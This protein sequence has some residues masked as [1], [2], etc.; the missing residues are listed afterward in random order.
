M[1]ISYPNKTGKRG[2]ENSEDTV[3]LQDETKLPAEQAEPVTSA[4]ASTSAPAEA[5]ET[6]AAETPK[7]TASTTTEVPATPVVL[8]L[9]NGTYIIVSKINGFKA[10]QTEGASTAAGKQMELRDCDGS[11]TQKFKLVG[12]PK[13]GFYTITNLLSGKVLAMKGNST[14]SGTSVVQNTAAAS[15]LGQKW[16]LVKKDGYYMF[17]SALDGTPLALTLKGGSTANGTDLVVTAAKGAASQLFSLLVSK[18]SVNITD[19]V[20]T[21]SPST[22]SKVVFDISGGSIEDR[23]NAQLFTSNG[24]DNQKYIVTKI[25]IIRYSICAYKSEKTLDVTGGSIKSGANVQLQKKTSASFQKFKFT[26]LF[27]GY[28][29]ITSVKSKHNLEV[30]AGSYVNKADLQQYKNTGGQAQQWLIRKN[31]DG[32]FTFINAKTSKAMDITGNSQKDSTQIQQY[33]R[34]TTTNAQRFTLTKSSGS[35]TKAIDYTKANV[36]STISAIMKKAQNYS[37]GYGDYLILVNRGAH[38][39]VTFEKQEGR[40]IMVRNS[41]CCV[42]KSST[43]TPTGTFEIYTRYYSFD[44][45]YNDAYLTYTCYYALPFYGPF[46]FHTILYNYGT[47]TVRDGRMNKN[48]SHGCVRMLTEEVKWLYDRYYDGVY[49]SKVVVYN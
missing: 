29:T 46:Y 39:V 7:T 42:G 8:P 48:I 38:R 12:D 31:A 15:V 2:G 45:D 34:S 23:A 18:P 13:A 44:G 5:K 37:K 4:A 14:A 49:G 9:Q 10:V 36:N 20:Y 27:N 40:W 26:N 41:P 25:G 30:Q 32:S 47:W 16:I 17:Q 24:T 43:P 19:G 35:D 21:I 6:T 3:P 1:H 22:N 11:N 33:T 28:Y